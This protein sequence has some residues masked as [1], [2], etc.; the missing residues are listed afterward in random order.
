MPITLTL[1]DDQA[2]EIVAQVGQLLK[3]RTR[4]APEITTHQRHRGIPMP[5]RRRRGSHP[6]PGTVKRSVLEFVEDQG[7]A[8]FTTN[9]LVTAMR[10]AGLKNK[11]GVFSCILLKLAR[12]GKVR[13]MGPGM[14][15][16]G[17]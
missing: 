10:K 4:K 9:V 7:M 11:R 6:A 14:W 17:D 13:E 2:L 16:K 1:T 5:L 8:P 3:D 15:T 12:E